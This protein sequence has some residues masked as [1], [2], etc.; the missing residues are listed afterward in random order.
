MTSS[1]VLSCETYVRPSDGEAS[2]RADPVDD[3]IALFLPQMAEE[4]QRVLSERLEKCT[5]G[6][7]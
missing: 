1:E 3:P 6:S 4:L 7:E 2:K 5:A